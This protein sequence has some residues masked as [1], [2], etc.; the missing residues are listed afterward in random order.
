VAPSGKRRR[1]AVQIVTIHAAKG[2]EYPVVFCPFLWDA[3]CG[4]KM[5]ALSPSTTFSQTTTSPRS[6]WAQSNTR[7]SKPLRAQEKTSGKTALAVRRT[8]P[9]PRHRCT[10][11]GAN[12]QRLET[13]AL[14][15]LLHGHEADP[16]DPLR[17]WPRCSG[18][19][20]P[21]LRSRP[22][23]PYAERAGARRARRCITNDRPC[24]SFQAAARDLRPWPSVAA[25]IRLAHDQLFRH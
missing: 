23:A 2:L 21:P 18:P 17:A 7:R 8:G 13:S 22:C 15:W 20:V 19:Q 25:C 24:L 3:S 1:S 4:G 10:L 12:V 14:A 5:R 16:N 6:I 9:A 11:P